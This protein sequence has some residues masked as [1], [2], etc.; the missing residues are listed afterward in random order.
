MVGCRLSRVQTGLMIIFQQARFNA[1]SKVSQPARN[2]KESCFS[3]KPYIKFFRREH[4]CSRVT[5]SRNL[6][7]TVNDSRVVL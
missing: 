4:S 1:V 6:F 7:C 3:G 2:K 5:I